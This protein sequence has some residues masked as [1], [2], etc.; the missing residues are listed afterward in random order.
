[1]STFEY[2][3]GKWKIGENLRDIL[4][5]MSG[6]GSA[7]GLEPQLLR[8]LLRGIGENSAGGIGGIGENCGGGSYCGA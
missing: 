2:C 4:D 8:V 6:A 5:S 3:R 7:V 1:M